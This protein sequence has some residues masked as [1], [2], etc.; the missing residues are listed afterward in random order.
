MGQNTSFYSWTIDLIKLENHC[1]GDTEGGSRIIPIVS[2]FFFFFL[3]SY[4]ISSC[5]DAYMWWTQPS[6]QGAPPPR[7]DGDIRQVILQVLSHV[8][9]KPWMLMERERKANL[10][11]GTGKALQ[12]AGCSRDKIRKWKD[13]Y[14]WRYRFSV[15]IITC[16]Q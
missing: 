12:R 16:P 6:P 3:S 7:E 15:M 11:W 10:G 5:A 4:F 14:T 2:G 1:A 9:D 13:L 8:K